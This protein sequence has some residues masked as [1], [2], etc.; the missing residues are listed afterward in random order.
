MKEIHPL[1]CSNGRRK[2]VRNMNKT[3]LTLGAS[4]LVLGALVILPG[5]VGAYR[6]DPSMESPDCTE[7]RHEE[8]EQAFETENYEAW[9]NLMQGKGRVTQVVNED[10]FARFVEAHRLA[11]EGNADEAMRIRQE[12]LGLGL[13]NGS[14]DGSGQGQG[15]GQGQKRGQ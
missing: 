5:T 10:N 12:E 14:G 13:G 6:G 3:L 11:E 1:T 15:E 9:A 7:E 8:M 4:A 2:E